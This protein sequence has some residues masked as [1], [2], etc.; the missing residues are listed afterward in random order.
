MALVFPEGGSTVATVCGIDPGTNNLGFC[1]LKFDLVTRELVSIQ[2]ETFRSDR[3][4]ESDSFIP[5]T[6]TERVERILAQ[7]NNLVRQL[8]YY[9][10]IATCCES[11]YYNSFRPNAFGAL[12]EIIFAIRMA[13]LEHN[14]LMRFF[15]YE[16]S[17]IKKA[18]GAGHISGKDAVKLSVQQNTEIQS[19][20]IG[21]MA[22]LDEHAIDA[23]S[24]CYTHY[25]KYGRS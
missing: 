3:M 22:L 6:H 9:R 21:D 18:V 11:P 5:L 20:L 19:K 8:N 23:I 10:P 4:L 25:N 24:V 7:K 15:T 17:V 1:A 16:P 12:V 14:K 13:C 2:A